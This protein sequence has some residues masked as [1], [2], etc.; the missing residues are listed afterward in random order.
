M[1]L[2]TTEVTGHHDEGEQAWGV[3]FSNPGGWNVGA[4]QLTQEWGCCGKEQ[5][6]VVSNSESKALVG[7][8]GGAFKTKVEKGSCMEVTGPPL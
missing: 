5:N 8:V 4:T 2:C 7:L 3:Q 1:G 6:P